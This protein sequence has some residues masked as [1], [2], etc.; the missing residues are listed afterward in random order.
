MING[1]HVTVFAEDAEAAREFFDDVLQL[2][3]IDAGGGWLIFA[4]P[5]SEVAFHPADEDAPGPPRHELYL[6][7]DDIE[8]TVAQL[9]ERGVEFAGD[10][11]DEGFGLVTKVCVPGA[12]EIG[13]YQPRHGRPPDPDAGEED[14]EEGSAPAPEAEAGS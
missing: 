7:C 9:R 12:G 4:L 8:E 13:L 10:V 11:S 1:A 6:M 3:S 5:P 2:K 14:E